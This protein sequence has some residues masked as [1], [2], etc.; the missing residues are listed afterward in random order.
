MQGTGR[1]SPDSRRV[2][3]I[4]PLALTACVCGFPGCRTT[5][6][7]TADADGRPQFDELT[8]VYE[9]VEPAVARLASATTFAEAK[10]RPLRTAVA[11][12]A[13]RTAESEAGSDLRLVIQTPIPNGDRNLALASLQAPAEGKGGNGWRTV[14]HRALPRSEMETLL[15]HLAN[16]GLFDS[17]ARLHS[18]A[19]IAVEIDG[20]RFEKSWTREPRLDRLAVETY[21]A[22]R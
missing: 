22:A 11:N 20:H 7:V 12:F 1:L 4:L 21:D 2:S 16:G 18:S 14:A 13:S 17:Q 8:V 9:L 10:A 3:L 15:S 19:R 6:V 5:H